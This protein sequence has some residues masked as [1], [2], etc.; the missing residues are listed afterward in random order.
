ME[1]R[2]KYSVPNLERAL[3]VFELLSQCKEGLTVSQ[4]AKELEVPRNS[5]FRICAT[6]REQGY[7]QYFRDTQQVILTR[8]LFSIG[9]SALADDNI[10]Q[11]AADAMRSLRDETKETVLLGTLMEREGAVLEELAGLHHFNFRLQRGARFFL[12]CTAPGKAILA[13]LSKAQQA[14]ILDNLK[15]TR[16]NKNTITSKSEL[17][18]ELKNIS[19]SGIS[20]DEAEQIEGCHCIAAPIMDQYGH[21]VASIWITG[22]SSRLP[23]SD[24]PKLGIKVKAAADKVSNLLGYQINTNHKYRC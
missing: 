9:Y 13:Y 21:P 4:I 5:I 17:L 10:V 15:L 1:E 16:F 2:S 12:H 6:L 11:L 23:I 22:P 24:F 3:R 7:I 14:S 20:Y 8:K 18:K 19:N